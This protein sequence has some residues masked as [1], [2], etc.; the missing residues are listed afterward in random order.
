MIADRCPAG[1]LAWLTGALSSV[2]RA[3]PLQGGGRGFEP[4]SAHSMQAIR[5]CRRARSLCQSVTEIF[6]T[7]VASWFQV[8]VVTLNLA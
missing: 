3:P 4:R 8:P 7:L 2:G 1:T 5:G 6:V